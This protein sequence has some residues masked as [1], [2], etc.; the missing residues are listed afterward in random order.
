[1]KDPFQ[2]L[3]AVVFD[4]AGTTID[5]GSRAPAAVFQEIFRRRGVPIDAAQARGPMGMAKREH[6]AAIAALPA[7]ARAWSEKYGRRCE[8][9]DIELMYAEF[10]PLQKSVLREHCEMIPGVVASIAE[11]RR[12]GLKIG[13]STGYTRELM[14]V[15]SAEAERQGYVPA[16][17]ICAEDAVRGRPAPYLIYEAARRLDAFPLWEMVVVDDTP[18]GIAAGRNAGCWTIGVT[19]TGNCVGLS[20][21]ELAALSPE[22]CARRCQSA[23]ETLGSAGAHAIIASVAEIVGVLQALDR[24]ATAGARP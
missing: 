19:R 21:S 24:R 4:W 3:K 14:Q 2:T 22:E 12:M 9:S 5:H 23:A 17:V 15:V 11:L 10:L 20:E 1:M 18:V 7:V 6:I 13:S 16:C 8:E